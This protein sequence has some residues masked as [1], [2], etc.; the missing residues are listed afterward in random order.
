MSKTPYNE[1]FDN[2]P[3]NYLFADIAKRVATFQTANPDAK[4]IRLG[5][6]DAVLP[7]VEKVRKAGHISIDKM[8]IANAGY[9]SGTGNQDLRQAI[10]DTYYDFSE[11]ITA[12]NVIV[13]SGAKEESSNIQEMFPMDMPVYT[14]DPVYPVYVN[15]NILA[16]RDQIT[17]L[18]CTKENDFLPEIPQIEKPSL[19]YL[20]FP[21][22]PTGECASYEHLSEWVKIA[23]AS[24]S[25][26]I[27]DV[28]YCDF[29][30][31]SKI[32]KS[33]FEIPGSDE[34]AIEIGSLS[35]SAGFT[36]IRTAWTAISN[37][38]VGVN[39]QGKE[40]KFIDLWERRQN[41]KFNGV[42][43]IQQSMAL[44]ALTTAREETMEQVKYY[45]KNATLIKSTFEKM[46]IECVGGINS[47]YVWAEAPNGMSG[48]DFFDLL[49]NE[50]SVVCTPGE[51]FGESGND[52]FRLSAFALR[53]NVEE[54]LEKIG[55]L[56]L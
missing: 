8:E 39:S 15:S 4:I 51:G 12:A 9:P 14:T 27:Y 50:C 40:E 24:G 1:N 16:G 43:E 48:W 18:P 28:A 17:T 45:M 53:E 49:L 32:P 3:P 52:Y 25:A 34:V 47:P 35:K 7:I 2:I 11:N 6:S 37:D 54:A 5:I 21:N 38:F 13:S 29:I 31:D 22:N 30:T 44:C 26:I 55:N 20:C 41:Y 33:I 19:I 36:N 46:N 56:K 23:R 10:V 42:S